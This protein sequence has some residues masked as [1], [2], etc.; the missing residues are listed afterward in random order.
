MVY[1]AFEYGLYTAHHGVLTHGAP[2]EAAI[3]LNIN[4]TYIYLLQRRYVT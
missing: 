4:K 2:I 1:N 3:L